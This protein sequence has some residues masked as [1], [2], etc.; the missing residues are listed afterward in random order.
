M[1]TSAAPDA[2]PLS[3]AFRLRNANRLEVL[4]Q[5][6]RC[7]HGDAVRRRELRHRV[8]PRSREGWTLGGADVAQRA[9]GEAAERGGHRHL[10][11]R[12]YGRNYYS[13]HDYEEIDSGVA[14]GLM[15]SLRDRLG[16]FPG[17]HGIISADDFAYDDRSMV[18]ARRA[19]A[20]GCCSRMDRASSTASPA[21]AR[22]VRPCA[23]TSS[24]T[25]PMRAAMARER[26]SACRPRRA[27]ALAW[28][29]RTAHGPRRADGDYLTPMPD[30]SAFARPGVTWPRA[31]PGFRCLAPRRAHSCLPVRG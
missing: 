20:S 14:N 4:R 26:G 2:W 10:N 27:V 16:I 18:R 11:W 12:E 6:A 7:R 17:Q 3:W 5:S 1:P 29:D 9:C 30:V 8:E 15:A 24:A 13:R 31:A 25:N 28:R 21:P 23:S 19:K 22:P